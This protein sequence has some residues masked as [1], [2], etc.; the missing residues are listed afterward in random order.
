VGGDGNIPK[1]PAAH[2]ELDLGIV[3]GAQQSTVISNWLQDEITA[4]LSKSHP[5]AHIDVKVIGVPY[6]R[7]LFRGRYVHMA[8]GTRKE[9]SGARDSGKHAKKS[10]DSDGAM[11]DIQCG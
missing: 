9:C 7:K 10:Q 5:D 4:V 3:P 6:H 8:H 1:F 11:G 2:M